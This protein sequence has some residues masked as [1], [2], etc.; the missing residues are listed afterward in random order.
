MKVNSAA[1]ERTANLTFKNTRLCTCSLRTAFQNPP[2]P[3]SASL[4]KSV[5]SEAE[6]GMRQRPLLKALTDVLRMAQTQKLSCLPKQAPLTD[7]TCETMDGQLL[8]PGP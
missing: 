5:I 8:A 6:N 3:F 1:R 7:G 2:L 4:V